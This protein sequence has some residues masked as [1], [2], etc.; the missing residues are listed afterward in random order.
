[1]KYNFD[2]IVNRENTASVKYDLR[3]EIFGSSDVIPMWVADMDFKTPDFIIKAIKE[4]ANHELFGYS[5]RPESYFTSIVNWLKR[6]HQWNVD[7]EWISFSPGIVPAV[8]MAILAYTNQGDKIIIQPPVYFPF[9]SAIEN[10]NRALV[11]NPLSLKNNRYHFD[12]DDLSDKLKDAKLLILSNPHNPGGS[13]WTREE[14]KRLGEMCIENNVIILSDE[15]HA[16][17]VFKEYKFTALAS[18]SDE[19]ANNTVTF[20]A[21]SKTF[22]MA[23]L[24]TSSVIAS[25]KD[26][27]EKYDKVLDTIHVG[28][29]NVFGTV[30][31][32]AAYNFGDEWL[33]QLM[34]YLSGNLDL[35]QDFIDKRISGINM[36]RPEGTYL[37]WLD[38]S[39][40]NLNGKDIK[41]FIIHD[42]GL[43]FND[44]KMFGTGGEGFVRMNIACPRET[45]KEALIKLEKALSKL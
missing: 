16:D 38:C 24:A 32:E 3:N 6:R 14:L 17:L 27:K 2:E 23:A 44:G 8:N 15:I 33:D 45:I 5:F 10:N 30:A 18:I 39:A 12:F 25:N 41:E 37:V 4:R 19:I 42:A 36:I 1:M 7:M 13:V 43:G 9:F 31:S 22:N 20:I 26:L 28:L 11:E 34:D 35:I 40:I 21:P 29:G